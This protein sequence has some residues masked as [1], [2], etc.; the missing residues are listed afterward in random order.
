MVIK[1]ND[2][3]SLTLSK[4]LQNNYLIGHFLLVPSRKTEQEG[5]INN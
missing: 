4:N 2:W 1:K 5:L 3:V